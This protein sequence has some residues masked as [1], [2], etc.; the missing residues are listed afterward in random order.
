V[1]WVPLLSESRYL[2]TSKIRFV[3]LPSRLVTLIKAPPEPFEIKAPAEVKSVPGRRI[4][5]PVAPA[6]RMAVTAA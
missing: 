6:W 4:L 5:L 1:V 3:V 2:C